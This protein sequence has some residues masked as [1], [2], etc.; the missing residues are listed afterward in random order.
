MNLLPAASRA[1]TPLG[2]LIERVRERGASR[3][4]EAR[5]AAILWTDPGGEWSHV[6]DLLRQRLP[7]LFVLDDE[8]QPKLRTGPA[9]WLRCAVD[10]ALDG[11]EGPGPRIPVL[12]LPRVG[13]QDLRAGEDC[14]DRLKPLV[15]LLHRG[16]AWHHPNGRDWTVSAFLGSPEGMD[17]KL[18]SDR[19]TAA[20]LRE[21]LGEVALTKL[22]QL[23]NR[24]LEADDFDRGRRLQGA[25]GLMAPPG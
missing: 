5:P 11:L 19:R 8:Y 23:R 3:D 10:G 6:L 17:L 14:P 20:S 21:A 4:G 25:R 7:E 16:V 15:E 2:F 24:R 13:R 18:A 9:I 12:Y 22:T 1:E